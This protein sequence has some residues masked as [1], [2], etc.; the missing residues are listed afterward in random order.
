[1]INKRSQELANEFLNT[2]ASL[3]EENMT[4]DNQ[5]SLVR[6]IGIDADKDTLES[7]VRKL[8]DLQFDHI[9]LVHKFLETPLNVIVSGLANKSEENVRNYYKQVAKFLHPDKNVHPKSKEAF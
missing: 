9:Y 1:M 8:S 6:K 7:Y 4:S 5:L 2:V 3:Q